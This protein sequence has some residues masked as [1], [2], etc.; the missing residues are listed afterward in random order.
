MWT[1][2]C[3]HNFKICLL[4]YCLKNYTFKL[5]RI[6]SKLW[7]NSYVMCITPSCPLLYKIVL[8]LNHKHFSFGCV[9]YYTVI[10]CFQA[11]WVELTCD[12]ATK[13]PKPASC[14]LLLLNKFDPRLSLHFLLTIVLE[15]Q[16]RNKK[17]VYFT[18]DN[19]IGSRSLSES[20]KW[21]NS[22]LLFCLYCK[23]LE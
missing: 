16:C 6:C 14:R 1:Y 17:N 3:F 8:Y 19:I 22:Y 18:H 11:M 7:I 23:K 5:I 9:S 15:V 21:Y 12:D 10:F 20:T 13:W 4:N 2:D